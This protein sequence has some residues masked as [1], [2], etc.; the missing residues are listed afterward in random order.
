[1]DCPICK[2]TPMITLEL[3][4]VEVDYCLECKG[5]WLDAGE[6]E[7]LL[8]DAMES[9]K[10]L[11]SFEVDDSTKEKHVRCPICS[12]KMQKIKIASDNKPIIIDRCKYNHGLW[13]DRGE[14]TEILNKGNL[15]SNHKIQV[16]LKD[17]FQQ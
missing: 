8:N 11:S 12:K 13:F 14:L 17:I 10:L 15:D 6:L 3:D 16:L 9:Q 1:M 7:M 4:D 5:I 2:N